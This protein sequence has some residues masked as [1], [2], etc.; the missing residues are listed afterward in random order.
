M[1]KRLMTECDRT[2]QALEQIEGA[3][4]GRI[5]TLDFEIIKNALCDALDGFT[6]TDK[7]LSELSVLREDLAARIRGMQ[8]AIEVAT[9]SSDGSAA[10]SIEELAALG[11]V[12]LTK[13]YRITCCRFR[14]TFPG[15]LTYLNAGSTSRTKHDWA[16]YQS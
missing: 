8:R 11:A 13:R 4:S 5:Q 3:F 15:K 12:D 2:K 6:I 14:D 7:A 9:D 16:D 10:D 1:A